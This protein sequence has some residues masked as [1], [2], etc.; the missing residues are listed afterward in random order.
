MKTSLLTAL[1]L[2]GLGLGALHADIDPRRK[3]AQGDAG[4]RKG[5]K[6]EESEKKQVGA[7]EHE[8][9]HKKLAE[10][11]EANLKEIAKLMEKIRN[12]LSQKQTGERTQTDQKEVIRKIDELIEKAGKG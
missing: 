6:K 2:L 10:E 5:D 4:D 7:D 1:A 11:G 8:A 12:D 3:E 9:I